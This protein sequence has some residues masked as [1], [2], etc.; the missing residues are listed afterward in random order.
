MKKIILFLFMFCFL[1]ATVSAVEIL[2]PASVNHSYI[3]LQTCSSCTFVNVTISN[4]NGIIFANEPMT[5]NG[6]GVWTFNLTPTIASRHDVAGIG[7]IDGVDTSFTTFFEVTGS[8]KVASTGD[9]ILYSLFSI[10]LLVIISGLFFFVFIVPNE[11]EKDE[12]GFENKIVKW[13]Y[14]RVIVIVLIYALTI[15]LLNFLNGLAI[16]FTALSM[17]SGIFGFLFKLMLSLAWVFT[18]LMIVWI[19]FMLIHDTNLKK[20]LNKLN[21]FSIPTG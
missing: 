14:F 12:R 18:I 3:V 11:N 8:G 10:I 20:Q 2:K 1:I 9:S 15:L 7:N 16:N 6:S 4:V 13:K 19:V 5:L 17:F 21:N